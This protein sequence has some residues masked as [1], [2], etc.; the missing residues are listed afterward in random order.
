[1]YNGD[2]MERRNAYRILV[3]I[4]EGKILILKP[5]RKCHDNIKMGPI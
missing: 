3:W 2:I 4:S 1:M 5:R